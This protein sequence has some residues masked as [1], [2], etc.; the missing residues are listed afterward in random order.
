MGM[1]SGRVMQGLGKGVPMMITA[2]LRVLIISVPLSLYFK[3]VLDKPIEYVW[4]S[5]IFSSV[6]ATNVAL[7]WL[8]RT[9]KLL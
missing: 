5:V 6:I 7:Q 8:R 9:L 3:F 2:L 1:T 4:Y